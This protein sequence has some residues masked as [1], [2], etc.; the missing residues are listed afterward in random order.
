MTVKDAAAL[1]GINTG[2]LRQAIRAGKIR[3]SRRTIPGGYM[4][5]V[6]E[7]AAVAYRDHPPSN[8]GRPRKGTHR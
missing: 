4:Y 8:R 1:I 3:A 7:K 6:S 2:T 5:E